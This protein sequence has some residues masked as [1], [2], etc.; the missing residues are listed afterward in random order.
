MTDPTSANQLVLRWHGPV[1]EFFT[2][3]TPY[4]CAHVE[5]GNRCGLPKDS[6]VHAFIASSSAS[7]PVA[8]TEVFVQKGDRW[9]H[10][11]HWATL[12][13]QSENEGSWFSGWYKPH[14][15][16]G[17]WLRCEPID[18][19]SAQQIGH[20]VSAA[21]AGAYTEQMMLDLGV[22]NQ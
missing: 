13:W 2:D 3:T 18:C 16:Q 12:A 1:H 6:Q 5:Y 14:N 17:V 8:A 21:C 11:I 10:Q 9:V 7:S 19:K 20:Y 15:N 4:G 22:K